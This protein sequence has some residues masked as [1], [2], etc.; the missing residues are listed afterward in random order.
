MPHRLHTGF[1]I[2]SYNKPLMSHNFASATPPLINGIEAVA[3]IASRLKNDRAR[4]TSQTW[5]CKWTH[6]T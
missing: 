3:P 5:F 4:K 1:A 6:G 2:A